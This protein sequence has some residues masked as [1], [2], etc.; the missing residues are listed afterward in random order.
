MTALGDHGRHAL[1]MVM[2]MRFPLVHFIFF[3]FQENEKMT[4]SQF[5]S[6]NREIDQGR[7]LPRQ[8]LE[9]MYQRV[10]VREMHGRLS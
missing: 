6:N 3:C 8:D 2:V 4:Q 5:V 1:V 7:D 9:A 10:K